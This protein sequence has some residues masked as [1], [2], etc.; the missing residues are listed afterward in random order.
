MDYGGA[1]HNTTP[2][3]NF[4]ERKAGDYFFPE[5]LSLTFCLDICHLYN[6]HFSFKETIFHIHKNIFIKRLKTEC[7]NKRLCSPTSGKIFLKPRL[8]IIDSPSW[9]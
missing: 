6:L 1:T 3:S 7:T 4:S 5:I 8:K 9:F 2:Y